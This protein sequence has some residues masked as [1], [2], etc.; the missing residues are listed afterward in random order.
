MSRTGTATAAEIEL[1]RLQARMARDVVNANTHGLSHEDSLVAPQPGGN[2]LN[3]VLGHLL[4]VYDGFL[5]LLKQEPVIG[6]ATLKRFARGAPPLENPA[7]AMDFPRLQAAWNQASDRVDAGLARLDPD[8]LEQPVPNS[9][10]GNPDETVRS[11]I[12]TVMFHQA[13][14]AGQTAVL[15]RI[16]GREGAIH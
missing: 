16:A 7:D 15:R 12:T 5:P 14:H 1:W 2:R 13:Y 4:S 11:L 3:W 10:S 8:T 6:A 9:P